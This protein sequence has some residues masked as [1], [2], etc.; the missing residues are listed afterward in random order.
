MSSILCDFRR[1]FPRN[2]CG[3]QG[4]VGTISLLMTH[5]LNTFRN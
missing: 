2:E 1:L 4:A 5:F 3:T